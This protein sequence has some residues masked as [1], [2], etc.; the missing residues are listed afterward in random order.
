MTFLQQQRVA[1]ETLQLEQVTLLIY[2]YSRPTLDPQTRNV[3]WGAA[4]VSAPR[5]M[6]KRKKQLR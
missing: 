3:T 2:I 6:Q 4:C 5:G 1:V